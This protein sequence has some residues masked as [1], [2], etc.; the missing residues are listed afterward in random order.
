MD[1]IKIREFLKTE[2]GQL[3]LGYLSDFM[4]EMSVKANVNAEW[5]R[6]MGMLINH[7][8]EIDEICQR[9]NEIDRR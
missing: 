1:Y 9:H 7:L 4:V 2:K 3:L 5:I 8:K 6:G